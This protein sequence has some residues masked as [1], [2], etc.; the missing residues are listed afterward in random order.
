MRCHI[1]NGVVATLLL[2]SSSLALAADEGLAFLPSD[3]LALTGAQE[4]MIWQATV[5]AD[6]HPLSGVPGFTVA[7]D[8]TV[9]ASLPLHPIPADIS[10]RFPVLQKYEYVVLDRMVILVNAAD[11]KIVDIIAR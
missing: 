7:L 4:T 9:P 11:R 8:A 5:P 6:A 10:D 3:D 2:C 1:R